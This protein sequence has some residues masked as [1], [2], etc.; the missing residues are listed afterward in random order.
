MSSHYWLWKM[1]HPPH[2]CTLDIWSGVTVNATLSVRRLWFHSA[3]M[4]F[5]VVTQSSR[6]WKHCARLWTMPLACGSAEPPQRAERPEQLMVRPAS[7]LRLV[8][9]SEHGAC[10]CQCSQL[11]GPSV[12]LYGYGEQ[13]RSRMCNRW[14]SR[15]AFRNRSS[16][17]VP[18][19]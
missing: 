11:I 3:R 19:T 17:Y 8:W 4:Q 18:A 16:I 1:K 6:G 5:T 10:W 13:A 14:G 7:A 12:S 2:V 9:L 15:A